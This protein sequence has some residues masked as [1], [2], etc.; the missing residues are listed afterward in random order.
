MGI[1]KAAA[2]VDWDAL[3]HRV[4]TEVLDWEA[5][6]KSYYSR[7]G[8]YRGRICNWRPASDIGQ[9]IEAMDEWAAQAPGRGWF[10]ESPVDGVDAGYGATLQPGPESFEA[11]IGDWS[12]CNAHKERACIDALLYT[13][14]KAPVRGRSS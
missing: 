13:L 6:G 4:A 9:C 10:L 7:D 1:K 5:R 2:E 12:K 3:G 8:I 14:D 11:S